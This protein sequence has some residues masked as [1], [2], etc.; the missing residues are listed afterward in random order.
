MLVSLTLSFFEIKSYD[1]IRFIKKIK[2]FYSVEYYLGQ[3]DP[4]Q[5]NTSLKLDRKQLGELNNFLKEDVGISIK[6]NLL[7]TKLVKMYNSPLLCI[8]TTFSD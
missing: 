6:C 5:L 4:E 2:S 8:R 3:F 1:F 7:F